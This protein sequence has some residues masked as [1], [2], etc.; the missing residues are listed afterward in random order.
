MQGSKLE[1]VFIKNLGLQA[2][3]PSQDLQ[4]TD[5]FTRY[6]YNHSKSKNR[7]RIKCWSLIQENYTGW[8]CYNMNLYNMISDTA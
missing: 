1:E 7:N 8:F 5:D 3:L 4:T 6:F 2:L